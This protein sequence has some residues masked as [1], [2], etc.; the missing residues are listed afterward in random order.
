MQEFQPAPVPC[1]RR[2]RN[3]NLHPTHVPFNPTPIYG[4]PVFW[5]VGKRRSGLSTK[6]FHAALLPGKIPRQKAHLPQRGRYTPLGNNRTQCRRMR[7]HLTKLQRVVS[8]LATV[9]QT[10]VCPLS[11]EVMFQPLSEPLQP[12]VRFFRPPIPAQSTASLTVRLPARLRWQPYRL[13]T[14]PACHTTDVGSASSPVA[15]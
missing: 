10:E 3:L 5:R 4:V 6:Y 14:F 8:R 7:L 15:E 1:S 11:R 2:L 9:D 12:G 13:T